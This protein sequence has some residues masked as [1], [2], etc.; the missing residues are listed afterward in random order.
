MKFKVFK[1]LCKTVV[2]G[3]NKT[4]QY[5]KGLEKAFG[6]DCTIIS[7][8][9]QVYYEG[10]ESALALEFNDTEWINWI[11]WE[12]KL[13]HSSR[14]LHFSVDDIDYQGTYKNI[15]LMLTNNLSEKTGKLFTGDK[16]DIIHEDDIEKMSFDELK[17]LMGGVKDD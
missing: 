17:D 13:S 7:N 5:D 6:K 2:D 3:V 15:Y 11:I 12:V 16:S 1:M 9:Q 8:A 4:H 10:I 14:D